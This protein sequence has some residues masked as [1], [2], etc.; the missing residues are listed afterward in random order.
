MNIVKAE[1]IFCVSA[2]ILID[3]T[4]RYAYG[5]VWLYRCIKIASLRTKIIFGQPTK[6]NNTRRCNLCHQTQIV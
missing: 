1:T 3:K 2:F 4:I 6:I 5:A